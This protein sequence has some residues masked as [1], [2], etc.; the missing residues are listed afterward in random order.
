MRQ[1]RHEIRRSRLQPCY[2]LR[3][4][5]YETKCWIWKG[6]ISRALGYGMDGRAY[7]HV[8]A[9]ETVY[10][11]VAPGT[12]LHHLCETKPCIRPDHLQP[13]TVSG[14]ARLHRK[15]TPEQAQEIRRA[16]GTSRQVARQFGIS[17]SHAALLRR[18]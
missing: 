11:Q 7:A 13:T 1:V 5:G 17:K 18:P 14:H 15:L 6:A 3:D 9:Y 4:C 10:G 16:P 2:E 8:A 12:V